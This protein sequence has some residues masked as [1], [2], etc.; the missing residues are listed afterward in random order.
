MGPRTLLVSK[1]LAFQV[2][3]D[4]LGIW[5]NPG[6]T[7]KSSE[8][9]LVAGKK[10]LPVLYGL[11]KKG[12]FAERWLRGSISQG[13]VTELAYLLETEGGRAYSQ[14]AAN[15]LTKEALQALDEVTSQG[16]AGQAL[17]ELAE[18]LLNRQV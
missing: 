17:T 15:R 2:M 4:I 11:G 8:S 1:R 5:G 13:E 12:G 10:S 16:E 18:L 14:E 7:G 9:D 3:D 6:Q